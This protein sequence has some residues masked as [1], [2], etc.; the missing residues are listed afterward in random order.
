MCIRDSYSEAMRECS[1]RG[2]EEAVQ[3][4]SG[5]GT[6]KETDEDPNDGAEEKDVEEVEEAGA[7]DLGGMAGSK[8]AAF[9]KGLD[10]AF[11]IQSKV[12][13]ER[14][15]IKRAMMGKSAKTISKGVD[16]YMGALTGKLKTMTKALKSS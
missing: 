12:S 4:E 14:N 8:D 11:D 15:P 5:C 16:D 7:A 1:G 13:A 10:A 2:Y 9:T 6:H 3:S